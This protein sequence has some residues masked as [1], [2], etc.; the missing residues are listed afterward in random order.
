MKL[1]KITLGKFKT[2]KK[3][4]HVERTNRLL[5]EKTSF[6][7]TEAYKA[8]RTN[9]MFILGKKNKANNGNVIVFTS[10]SAAE[11]KTTTCL[12]LALTIAQAGLRVLVIDADMRKPRLHKLFGIDASPGLS[13]KLSGMD[14]RT[15]V[16]EISVGNLFVMPAGTTAALVGKSGCGKSTVFRLLCRLADVTKGSVCIDGT[17]IN[18][19]DRESIRGNITV[20]SQNPYLFHLSIR[21]NLRLVKPDLTD[22]EMQEVCGIAQIADDIKRMPQGYDSLIGEG[23]VNLSGGQRQRL[24]IARS[25]LRDTPIMLLDEATSALDNVTQMEIMKGLDEVR[26]GRTLVMIAHR[27]STVINADLILFIEDGK[28]LDQGTH[29]E[30][31]ERCASYRELYETDEQA[32]GKQD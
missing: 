14:E 20:V 27:L 26:K 17:D 12:N 21:D 19:L 13:D 10:C 11:G 7:A 31:L 30:L 16:Y 18:T 6:Q 23:G 9:L 1:P 32:G 25:L 24:A 5:N 4:K 22:E 3:R 29:Q 15:C 2:K 28:I 8:A